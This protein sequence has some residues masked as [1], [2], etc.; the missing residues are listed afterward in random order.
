MYCVHQIN[1]VF[2]LHLPRPILVLSFETDVEKQFEHNRNSCI[3]N[4]RMLHATF[5]KYN[6]LANRANRSP[7]LQQTALRKRDGFLTTFTICI[8]SSVFPIFDRH[9]R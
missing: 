9:E 3:H 4:R 8:L 7:S 6:L 2:M 1:S 5:L